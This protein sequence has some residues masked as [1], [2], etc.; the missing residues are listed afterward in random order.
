MEVR[1]KL[2]GLEE[3]GGLWPAAWM[4]GNLGRATYTAS[5]SRIWPWSY[6]PCLEEQR[7]GQKLTGCDKVRH[8]GMEVGKGRGAVEID[9]FEVMVKNEDP[10]PFSPDFPQLTSSLQITPGRKGQ[11]PFQG[12]PPTDRA[13]GPPDPV[14]SAAD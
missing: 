2:P 9:L 12:A 13:D 1:A 8:Y 6:E 14:A 5:T 11:R 10:G 3:R 7:E 4:M